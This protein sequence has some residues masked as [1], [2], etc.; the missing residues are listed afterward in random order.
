[1]APT[2]CLLFPR[3]F[4]ASKDALVHGVIEGAKAAGLCVVRQLIRQI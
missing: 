4:S 2:E 3:K 1:M